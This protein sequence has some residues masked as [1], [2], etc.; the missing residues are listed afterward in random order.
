MQN[1][2]PAGRDALVAYLEESMPPFKG[3]V[4]IFKFPDGQSN[5]TYRLTT[6]G[7]QYVLRR[8]PDG[9]LLPSAHAVD[10]EYRV[11]SALAGAGIPVPRTRHLCTDET[12]VGTVFFVME[13]VDGTIFWNPSLPG[14]DPLRRKRIYDEMNR[15]LAALHSVNPESAGLADFGKPGSYF[16]RQT[17]R[18]TRQYQHS[19]TEAIAEM[20]FLSGWLGENLPEDD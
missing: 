17:D 2:D 3:P 7:A 12:I 15:V 10:R 6:P 13:H 14:L 16:A 18:W 8:K 19:A 20:D 1:L 5:P 9:K 4:E 11:M